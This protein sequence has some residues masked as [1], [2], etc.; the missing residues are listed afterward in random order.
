MSVHEKILQW[1]ENELFTGNLQFGQDLPDDR[2]LASLVGASNS[3][4]REALKTLETMGIVRLYDGKRKA[5]VPHLYSSPLASAGSALRLHMASARYPLRDTVQAQILLETWAVNRAESGS[6]VVQELEELLKAMMQDELLPPDFHALEVDFHIALT[7][8]SGNHMVTAMMAMMRDTLLETKIEMLGRVSLWSAFAQ[9][10]RAEYQAIVE[11]VKADDLAVATRL[12]IANIEGQ[13]ED[14]DLDLDD[15]ALLANALPG[16]EYDS[17][18]FDPV[19]V[20][21]EDSVPEEWDDAPSPELLAALE[22]IQ[23]VGHQVVADERPQEAEVSTGENQVEQEVASEDRVADQ[24]F[25]EQAVPPAESGADQEAV[26]PEP[27]DTV[28]MPTA[29]EDDK[30]LRAPAGRTPSRR[31]KGRVTTPVHATVIPPRASSGQQAVVLAGQLSQA[32]PV[33][34]TQ[35]EAQSSAVEARDVVRASSRPVLAQPDSVQVEGEAPV[36]ALKKGKDLFN[37]FFGVG[38]QHQPVLENEAEKVEATGVQADSLSSPSEAENDLGAVQ[39]EPAQK[40]RAQ[41]RAEAKKKAAERKAAARV[42]AQRLQE[43]AEAREAAE[44]AEIERLAAEQHRQ[45]SVVQEQ[46]VDGAEPEYSSLPAGYVVYDG[47]E[48]SP[49]YEDDVPAHDP[50][51]AETDFAHEKSE[52]SSGATATG[53]GNSI[54]KGKKKKKK[55][56]R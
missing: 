46:T 33:S 2:R 41:L 18:Y 47:E 23:P 38:V 27:E 5:I 6:S 19:E 42:E 53:G 26:T 50:E 54:T 37:R 8:L 39:A 14:A 45:K 10:A 35:A 29:E 43:E 15:E 1:M 7:K 48:S 30:I 21:V 55:K 36:S 4:T 51:P 20:E 31:L 11:A 12:I 3:S 24:P 17:S 40:T 22:N 56:R 16:E 44:R 9:R 25:E 13:Y 52:G 28:P 32:Q 49:V 34:A